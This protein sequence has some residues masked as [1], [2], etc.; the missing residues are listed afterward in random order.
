MTK[1]EIPETTD[2][3]VRLTVEDY[4]KLINILM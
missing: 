4:Q 3:Q 1:E 2:N